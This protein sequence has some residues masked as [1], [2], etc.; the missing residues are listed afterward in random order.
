MSEARIGRIIVGAVHQAIADVMPMR[1]EFYE[2]YL[3]PMRLRHGTIGQASFHAA[4]S[5]LRQDDEGDYDAVMDAAG[6]YAAEWTFAGLGPVTRLYWRH[7]PRSL[8]AR[9][10]V[11]LARQLVRD[12]MPVSRARATLGQGTAVLDVRQSVFCEVRRPA[13]TPLCGFYR[14]A[15]ARFFDEMRLEADVAIETCRAVA[16]GDACRLVVT[17]RGQEQS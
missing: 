16:G 11:R 3:K 1:L 6:R 12:T 5:F 13:A 15:L 17:R 14:A 2:N 10:A 7:A 4:L 8:R 9:M